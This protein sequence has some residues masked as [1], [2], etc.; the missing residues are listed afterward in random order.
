MEEYRLIGGKG[1]G[2]KS[3]KYFR[4]DVQPPTTTT[5]TTTTATTT[6]T[7]DYLDFP[8]Y[9]D[10]AKMKASEENNVTEDHHHDHDEDHDHH[11]YHYD[12]YEEY[13]LTSEEDMRIHK[14]DEDP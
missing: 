9:L 14:D 3:K 2:K 5:T 8:N 13:A 11:E 12:S 1:S 4:I 10:G 6:V 7:E